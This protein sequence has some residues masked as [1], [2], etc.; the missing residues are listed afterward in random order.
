MCFF[1]NVGGGGGGRLLNEDKTLAKKL[2]PF[3][4]KDPKNSDPPLTPF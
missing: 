4:L 1:A 2:W 3:V